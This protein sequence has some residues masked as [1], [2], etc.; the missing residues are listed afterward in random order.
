MAPPEPSSPS[1]AWRQ[2]LCG[3]RGPQT[4]ADPVIQGLET[5]AGERRA[6]KAGRRGG[7]GTCSKKG[8][9][10][11]LYLELPGSLGNADAQGTPQP[12]KSE[13]W[14]EEAS[15]NHQFRPLLLKAWSQ[16]SAA[17]SPGSTLDTQA[18]GP[19]RPAPAKNCILSTSWWFICTS[20][21]EAWVQAVSM[22]P[23]CGPYP[24]A[25]AGSG[26]WR[27]RDSQLVSGARGAPWRGS[28]CLFGPKSN[29]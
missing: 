10:A 18:L 25:R 8:S 4:C 26:P 27:P 29:S 28:N 1:G 19:P 16:M 9:S 3:L 21:L 6:L 22:C 14:G 24:P 13:S 7:G 5:R 12:T 17:A 23:A 2:S 20:E 11:R 15:E